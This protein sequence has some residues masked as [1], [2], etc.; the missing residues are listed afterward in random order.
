M[1]YECSECGKTFTDTT[2]D[3]KMKEK[4][5]SHVKETGHKKFKSMKPELDE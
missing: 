2:D 1:R 5:A 3:K 4:M